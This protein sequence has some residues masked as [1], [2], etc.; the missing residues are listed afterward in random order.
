MTENEKY[1][2]DHFLISI[3]SGFDSLEDIIDDTLEAIEDEG[4]ESEIPEEWVKET[5]TREY[6]KNMEESKK[7]QHPTDTEK[8]HTVFDNLCKKK[9]VALHNAGYTLSE[10][11]YD[12]QEVW[13]DLT[14]IGIKPIG[15]CYY[16]GQDLERVIESGSLNIG[17][18]GEKPKNDKEA[19]AIANIIVAE[20]KS[21]GFNVNWNGSA[22]K[23]IEV[24]GFNW[25][26]TFTSDE[27]FEEKWGYERV[28]ELMEE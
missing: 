8:L 25:Q 26:N 9:I 4:W 3:K 27:D 13:A 6:N 14:D 18:D 28:S 11:V 1:L 19:I 15:Y 17:F 20:L 10:A 23:R 7:W 16:H 2:Y 5:V 24:T 12:C 21:A 22:S